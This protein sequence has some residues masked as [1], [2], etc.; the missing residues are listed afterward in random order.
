MSNKNYFPIILV[1]I[2]LAIGLLS[3]KFIFSGP[4]GDGSQISLSTNPNPLQPGPASFIIVVK[5]K[6]G[7]LVD[8]A[9]VSFDLNMVTMDMGAQK[10]DATP[11]GDGQYLAVGRMTM[12]GPWLL[13]AKVTLPDGSTESKDFSVNVP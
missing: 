7:Q 3:F 6:G 4:A 12:R 13:G 8:N 9:K 1:V 5:D 10:G 11:Q 2:I